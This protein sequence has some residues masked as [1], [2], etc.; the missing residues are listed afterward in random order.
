MKVQL[1]KLENRVENYKDKLSFIPPIAVMI[2]VI[3]QLYNLTLINAVSFFSWTQVLNEAI[4]VAGIMFIYTSLIVLITK[5]IS[6]E[7]IRIYLRIILIIIIIPWVIW[8]LLVWLDIID[9][10]TTA[11]GRSFTFY[12]FLLYTIVGAWYLKDIYSKTFFKKSNI[13]HSFLSWT[14]R[15]AYRVFITTWYVFLL[16]ATYFAWYDYFSWSHTVLFNYK[17]KIYLSNY[18]NDKFIFTVTEEKRLLT[19]PFSE[20]DGMIT[21]MMAV[22][23]FDWIRI[24]FPDNNLIRHIAK[25]GIHVEKNWIYEFVELKDVE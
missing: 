12:V 8:N 5:I 3:I 18:F 19:V 14:K 4:N 9:S 16:V 1:Q 21:P 17:D 10:Y 13:I 24:L 25:D 6:T 7:K 23:L 2:G 11:L 20:V 22:W 15:I